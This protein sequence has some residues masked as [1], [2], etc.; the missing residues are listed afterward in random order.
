[1]E[2]SQ[3]TQNDNLNDLSND[4]SERK[5]TPPQIESINLD[6]PDHFRAGLPHE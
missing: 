5:G 1:M 4:R 6:I 3:M 2:P